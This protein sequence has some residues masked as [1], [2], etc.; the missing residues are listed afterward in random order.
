MPTDPD[1]PID[2][3]T[4]PEPATPEPAT[5]GEP[6][7]RSRWPRLRWIG[8]WML[9][10]TLALLLVGGVAGWFGW[11]WF[12]REIL[13]TLPPELGR[14]AEFR[15]PCSV[16]VF[17]GDGSRVDQFYLER[18]VWVPIAE[19]PKHVWEAF[20]A[21]EDRR[22][23]EHE[24]VDPIGIVRAL[25]VNLRGGATKQGGSTITQQLVKNLLVGKERSYRRKLR[26]AVLAYRLEGEL[27]KMQLLELYLN[28]IPLGSGN[29]G[30]EAAAQDYFGISARDLNPGQAAM[31]AGLV[32]APSKY[33]PRHDPELAASR[34]ETVLKLMV[35]QG[36][37]DAVE[38][39]HYLTD[40]VLVQRFGS[41]HGANTTY[42]TETRR[43]V[44]RL[45][46]DDVPFLE[47]LQVQTPLDPRVQAVV[48]DSLREGLA[49]L[50]KRE[51]ARGPTRNIPPDARDGFLA[52]GDGLRLDAQT[53]GFRAPRAG[54]CFP[55]LAKDAT[56][57][58]DAGNFHF[59]LDPQDLAQR[60]RTAP[61]KPARPLREVL[62]DGD[63]LDVCVP[64]DTSADASD[65]A[66]GTVRRRVRPWA[67]SAAV[68]LENRTGHVVAISGGY[69]VGLEG[70]DRA[71]QAHRQPGSSF[72]PFV[73]ATAI[74]NG[75]RQTDIVTDAPFAIPGT[76][77]QLWRPKNYD[78][79]YHGPI[80]LRKAIALSLN[81]V[82][83]RLGNTYGIEKVTRLAAA[84][85]V[86]T[87]LRSDLT[88]ALGSSEVTPMDL[89]LGY[90]SI[91]RLG[92][93]I[94]PVWIS[95]VLDRRGRELAH[96][97]AAL[98]L[99]GVEAKDMPG[100][101]GVRAMDPA[102]AYVMVDMMR[103]VFREGTAKKG[104]REGMDFA[105]K[106]GTTSNFVDAWFVGYSP[107][108]TVA[109]W[110]GTDG[111]SSIGDAET[112]GKAA[113]PVWSRIMEALPNEKGERF[114]VPDDVVL[115]PTADGW[116]GYARG[117]APTDQ[118]AVPEVTGDEPLPP[119]GG[120]LPI[121]RKP[122]DPEPA[123]VAP[124]VARVGGEPV[125]G[126]D[127]EVGA[128]DPETAPPA[129]DA[130]VAP[131]PEAGPGEAAPDADAPAAGEGDGEKKQP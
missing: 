122:E 89:A 82:A 42:L 110:I 41:D 86:R 35:E 118:L 28:Y 31:L 129:T 104:R 91:A 11:R 99:P 108:Y 121:G 127:V 12:D 34:R 123:V 47:G 62:R 21:S 84:L 80:P 8:R 63:V 14:D 87:P 117:T 40:P 100:G 106:T 53:G 1:D 54:E 97:G 22:F 114:P 96:E 66:P 101:A 78:G 115:L 44:R 105:G 55:A 88:V 18:R 125:T 72:K 68:V 15:I 74:A 102:A 48:D 33:S 37:V 19:L 92:V 24:G 58:M 109:V 94:D 124:P 120:G 79:K 98:Q 85:G 75:L 119:F 3:P 36:F 56:G 59:H 71:T 13:S 64:D 16:Q 112:G 61:G 49:E 113:L 130:T 26:E 77:G 29:Y 69:D 6:P 52:R 17:A 4:T 111:Q 60:V 126:G 128:R 32:P 27:D 51:G 9:R 10:V 93:R 46:G 25:A 116:L 107:R 7:V 45:F 20:I 131:D 90:S 73:Y 50:E 57:A 83:V 103:N 39:S 2:E 43:E 65:T 81:T 23:F 38:A 70:F 76:N 67:E 95:R 5:L 30:V